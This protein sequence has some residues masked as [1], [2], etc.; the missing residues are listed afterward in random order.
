MLSVPFV[1]S[2]A[3]G[4]F[5]DRRDKI[6]IIR[7]ACLVQLAVVAT[8]FVFAAA[9]PIWL[10]LFAIFVFQAMIMLEG[11][12]EAALLP[13]I[14][15]GDDLV[16]ANA[17]IRIVGTVFGLAIGAFLYFALDTA[18]GFVVV[19]GVK[20]ALFLVAVVFSA[21][22]RVN[23]TKKPAAK[24]GYMK[25]YLIELKAG[26]VFARRGAALHLL[27]A[28]TTVNIFVSF[29]F[30]NTPM[31]AELHTG[32]AGGYIILTALT[33]AGVAFGSYTAQRLGPKLKIWKILTLSLVAAGLVRITFTYVI[34][35]D[36]TLSLFPHLLYTSLA[37]TAALVFS[38]TM[39]KLPPKNM[40]ARI[41]TI[42]T[43]LF[44]V[45]AALGALLGGLAGVLL[46]DVNLIFIIHG[47][48]YIVVGTGLCLS[49]HIR[50]LPKL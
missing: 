1:A 26:L 42:K 45:A 9:A 19:Y 7:A 37:G 28:F 30:V 11:P 4:P 49:K 17:L 33:W 14:V 38:T 6:K 10:L 12:A 25:S 5:V 27:M 24:T 22:I 35:Q 34:A 48:S 43:S 39:Q 29:A 21:L 15:S 20:A 31:F 47:A 8:L 18:T 44:S 50:G 40:I 23:E 2:F 46:G 36:F 41:N 3:V 16:K 32:Q 13:M